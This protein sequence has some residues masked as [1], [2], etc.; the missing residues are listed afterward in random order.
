MGASAPESTSHA[1]I[2]GDLPLQFLARNAETETDVQKNATGNF[3]IVNL[4]ALGRLKKHF[5]LFL[6]AMR[7]FVIAMP[8]AIRV[9]GGC[10]S[11][12]LIDNLHVHMLAHAVLD[13][14]AIPWEPSLSIVIT[15]AT[16]VRHPARL[17]RVVEDVKVLEPWWSLKA[18]ARDPEQ[19]FFFSHPHKTPKNMDVLETGVGC[20]PCTHRTEF[21][22][23][24]QIA[25]DGNLHL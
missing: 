16:P 4:V 11:S 17:V 24:S 20:L 8:G 22:M 6:Q 3:E 13:K 9:K 19:T 2:P 25:S 23:R 10:A 18:S 7:Q 1:A 5:S 14:R 12:C 21:L 15:K